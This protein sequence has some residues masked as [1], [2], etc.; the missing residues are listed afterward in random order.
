MRL[1][2]IEGVH[3][4]PRRWRWSRASICSSRRWRDG[5]SEP[6]HA[7]APAQGHGDGMRKGRAWGGACSSGR[8]SSTARGYA[9]T[10]RWWS[11]RGGSRRSCRRRRAGRR[12]VALEGGVLS[13]GFIDLQ[14]NGGDGMML[15]DR[16]GRRGN[17]AICAAHGRLGTTGLLPTLVTDTPEA[18][19]A[20]VEAGVAAAER[21]SAGVSR[22]ASRGAAS[23]SAAPG[24]ARSL[25]DPADGGAISRCW[26]SGA[27]AA[28]AAGDAGAGGGQPGADRRAGGG[29]GD[30]QPRAYRR[31]AGG[32]AAAFAA[33]PGWSRISST[34]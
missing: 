29:R 26:A 32:A 33:G 18:T 22:A 2:S 10:R 5:G 31:R 19:R 30:R 3:P 15:N 14:V 1:P 16:L 25:A 8:R 34:R 24:G 9:P 6:R 11:R 7:A 23:R 13:P 21:G 12:R 27:A 17:R 4:R 20:T 28:R